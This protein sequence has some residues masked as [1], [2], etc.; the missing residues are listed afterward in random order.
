MSNKR[1]RQRNTNFIFK[2]LLMGVKRFLKYLNKNK[3]IRIFSNLDPDIFKRNNGHNIN[4][5][6]CHV[7]IV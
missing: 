5:P 1:R 4:Y 2:I 3:I 7:K 6:S